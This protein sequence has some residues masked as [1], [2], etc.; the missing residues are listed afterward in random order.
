LVIEAAWK[1][2]WKAVTVRAI[3]YVM[4]G[5]FT[6]V[7]VTNAHGT[8]VS[9]VFT[10]GRQ[11]NDAGAAVVIISITTSTETWETFIPILVTGDLGIGIHT[12]FFLN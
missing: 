6:I 12:S 11:R 1:A 2:A 5:A 9:I 7:A 4:E 8:W 10:H 3:F